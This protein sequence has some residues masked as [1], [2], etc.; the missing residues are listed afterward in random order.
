[1]HEKNILQQKIIV[2][3][4]EKLS[5]FIKSFFESIQLMITALALVVVIGFVVQPTTVIGSSMSPTLESGEILIV[6]KVS[7]TVNNINRGDVITF[8]ETTNK[9]LVK[10][11]IGL[12]GDRV[13]I[14][15]GKVYVNDQIIPEVYLSVENRIVPLGTFFSEGQEKTVPAGSFMVLGDNRKNSLDSRYIGFINKSQVIGKVWIAMWPLDKIHV[16]NQVQY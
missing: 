6:E 1:M 9:D 4:K 2:K 8:S 5:R 14:S 7:T 11:V 15:E 10:R 13:K 3:I 16:F 12:P